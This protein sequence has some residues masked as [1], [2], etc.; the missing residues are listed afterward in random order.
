MQDETGRTA[1]PPWPVTPAPRGGLPRCEDAGGH[2]SPLARLGQSLRE[3]L[4]RIAGM[5]DYEGYLEHWRR[6]HPDRPVPGRAEFFERYLESRYG[7]GVG[8]CC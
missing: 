2:L 5:P 7:G 4:Y 3:V 1:P 8:R 6:C